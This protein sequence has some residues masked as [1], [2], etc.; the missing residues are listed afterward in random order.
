MRI[1][2]ITYD[3]FHLKTEQIVFKYLDNKKIEKI[4]LYALP[5]KERKAR[6]VIFSHRPDM[7]NS[8]HTKYLSE[9][10][11]VSFQKW[12]GEKDISKKN[13]LF[14]IAG[15]G[16]LKVDFSGGKPIVNAHPG[17][18]P[19]TRGLDSFKWA[20][21]NGDPIGNTL[22]LIDNEVDK[23]EILD[24][25]LTKVFPTDTLDIL[26]RRHY[27]SEID[28]LGSVLDII[29]NRVMPKYEEKPATMRM[30]AE[31]EKEMIDKF[32]SWKLKI[33][34]LKHS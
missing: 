29:E 2:L 9:L 31:K 30:G 7:N 6:E 20:I 4:N 10:D 17:I 21:Y 12:D 3:N 22:H 18:I 13:D 19:I 28:M 34:S 16:I 5:F 14:V 33:I 15:A 32:D 8:I 23:G 1:G 27:E 25:K 11:K 26:A 24:I